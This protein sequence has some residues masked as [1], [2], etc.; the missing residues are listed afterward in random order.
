MIRCLS[1]HAEEVNKLLKIIKR[2]GKITSFDPNK[3]S[4]AIQRAASAVSQSID[5]VEELVNKILLKVPEEGELS[6]YDVE[7]I[8]EQFLMGSKYKNTARS[9]IEYRK[10]RDI[11]RES[12]S[13]LLNRVQSFI[14]R[15]SSEYTNENSNKDTVV[16]TSHRDLLAGIM[17]KYYATTQILSKEVATAHD[18]GFIHVH[19]TDYIISPL[20]NCI[21]QNGWITIRKGDDIN[22]IRLIDFM[23]IYNLETG[24]SIPTDYIE[25][26]SRSG[27][28]KLNAVSIRK[29]KEDEAVYKIKT[30]NGLLLKATENH[31]VPVIANGNE[32]LKLV[33]D[34]EE[35]Y[36]LLGV[37]KTTDF[38]KQGILDLSDYVHNLNTI[39][40]GGISYLKS[41]IN[42]KFGKTLQAFMEDHNIERNRSCP[43]DR[44]QR[45]LS[46]KQ[47]KAIKDLIDIPYD[48]YTKL[49]I[50]RTGGKSKIPLLLRVSPEFARMLGYVFADGCVSKSESVGSYQVTFSNTNELYLKDYMHC[51]KTCFPTTNVCIQYPSEKNTTPCTSI[52]IANAVIWELF[53]NFK[54]NSSDISIPNFVSNADH[55]IK[56][57]FLAGAFDSDGHVTNSTIGYTTICEKYAE[58]FVTL[59]NSL[60]ITS[61]LATSKTKGKAYAIKGVCGFRNGDTYKI[62]INKL[63]DRKILVKNCNS[64]KVQ[65]C[66]EFSAKYGIN[67]D[68][69]EIVSISKEYKNT[70]FVFDLETA[71]HWFIVND[72]VVHNCSLV[73]YPDML[74]NG[75]KIGDAAIE[76]PRSI[77]VAA[78][79]LTQIVQ[80]VASAQYGGTTISHIDTYLAPYVVMSYKKL[81][82]EALEWNLPEAWVD[83]RIEKEVYDAMQTLLYQVNSL[84]TSNGQTP[85]ITISFGLGTNYFERLIQ[86]SYLQVH[87]EGIGKNHVTPAFPKVVM[88]LQEGIN[89]R[90]ED[91]NYD[92]KLM[93]IDCAVKRIY[94]DFISLPLNKK[95][96]G[97]Y[98]SA[99]TCMGCRSFLSKFVDN[100]GKEKTLGRFNLG[101]VSVN[102]PMIAMEAKLNDVNIL[103]TLDSY[104]EIAYDAHMQRINLLKNT[105]A[106]QNPIMWMQGALAR[107]QPEETIEH[108]FYNGYASI[109][110][111]Y[112]GVA[113]MCEI[114]KGNSDKEFALAIL[115]HIKD[116]CA[117][118]TERSNIAFSVYGTP[119]EGYCYK[120]ATSFKKLFGTDI[121]ERDYLTNSFHQPVWI[122]SDP[123]S[124]WLYEE[125]FADI[126]SGGNISY[127]EQ[128]NL[129]HNKEAYEN[130]VDFAYKHIPYFGINMPVDH[131]FKCGFNGEFKCTSKGFVCPT[132]GNH[133]DGTMSV[134][135]RVSGYLSA[136]NS[137]P[138]NVGKQAECMDRVKHNKI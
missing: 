55:I 105:K 8:V 87:T 104:L 93:A 73:N 129:K 127:V 72:Y 3:I 98:D 5:N 54:H 46:I 106:K 18:S 50:Y 70:E 83:M 113:E 115:K 96:T 16:V 7:R 79:V 28:V 63:A 48:V 138:F 32:E 51:V 57:N 117:E 20:G 128:P 21:D 34:I 22:T 100:T 88:F 82:Q 109:S 29:L 33:K 38:N 116:K 81:Q 47:F 71:D 95:I 64:F 12:K 91:V 36:S 43:K 52:C 94:P 23:K 97:A 13:E 107:L 37:P 26:M 15:T 65:N 99:T 44:N 53:Y 69:Q 111:G 42:Y 74:T 61:C 66:Q 110:I 31:R 14:D 25:I 85:F 45:S 108:L 24:I 112:I 118:F 39:F 49:T 2:D 131:C 59:L 1:L 35:G 9:Y 40:I 114:V 60:G 134:I 92:I 132:C 80:A 6:V 4:I 84:T 124:K 119:S 10:S 103:D 62:N 126:S 123:Y 30:R 78:T 135:R 101:V 86:R 121:I 75:F 77:G 120:A 137:R 67:F 130:L 19:D 102:L 125:G 56:Y 68:P 11:A 76:P 136:P 122:D 27:W 90:P 58:Q 17:S 41:Y 89:M 133:E